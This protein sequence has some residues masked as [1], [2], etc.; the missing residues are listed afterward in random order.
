MSRRARPVERLFLDTAA[1]AEAC[2]V[3]RALLLQAVRAGE[4]RGRRRPAAR[5][6]NAKLLFTPDDLRAWV[7]SWE[8]T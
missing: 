6:R 7:S 4:L 8:L 5:G 2:S 3:S 1:A